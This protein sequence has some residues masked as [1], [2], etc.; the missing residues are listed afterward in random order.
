MA[1]WNGKQLGACHRRSAKEGSSGL[2]GPY[3]DRIEFVHLYGKEGKEQMVMDNKISVFIGELTSI[4]PCFRSEHDGALILRFLSEPLIDFTPDT[5]QAFPAAAE[6]W[7]LENKGL[8]VRLFLRHGVS[9]HHGREVV[10]ED[11]VYSWN[12]LVHPEQNS[13][14]AYHLSKI[15][16]FEDVR[17]GKTDHMSGLEVVGPYELTVRLTEPFAE[18]P[19]LFGHH[20]T[21]AVPR[22]LVEANPEQFRNHVVSTGPYMLAEPWA[23][24]RL[25]RF[26]GYYGANGAFLDGGSGYVEE[27][28]FRIYEDLNDAYTDW[29]EG[30]LHMMSAKFDEVTGAVSHKP[31]H[32]LVVGGGSDLVPQLRAVGSHVSTSVIVR[33]TVLRFVFEIEKNRKVLIM[34]EEDDKETWV[35]YARSL[36]AL[37]PFDSVASFAEI[38]QDKAAAISEALG[39][40]YHSVSTIEWVHGKLRMREQLQ[41]AGVEAVPNALVTNAAQVLEYG[42]S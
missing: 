6:S 4:D 34:G 29:K 5:G 26:D 15:E 35:D 24:V 31:R 2:A 11:Y 38:D 14:L 25:K 32:I 12:R 39:L 16:G 23:H 9:F 20:C 22:E 3:I 30:K 7:K 17:S 36:H 1:N 42:D 40:D 21:A 27:I 19:A 18:V 8:V 41:A 10:A 33:P 37:D 28:E 13:E